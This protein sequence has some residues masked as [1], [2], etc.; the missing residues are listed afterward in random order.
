MK[1]IGALIL[2]TLFVDAAFSQNQDSI[3][4]IGKQVQ[5]S[6]T[7]NPDSVRVLADA[8]IKV[9]T[10]D[11][12][13]ED[14]GTLMFLD[15][16]YQRSEKDD[17]LEYLT[18]TVAKDKTKNRPAFISI[19]VPNNVSISNGIF[20]KFGN[21]I[22]DKD[23]NRTIKLE[24]GNP[25]RIP[26]EQSNPQKDYYSARIIDGYAINEDTKEKIDIFQKFLSSDHVYFLFI[27]PDGSHKSVGVPLFSFKK[28]YK[29]IGIA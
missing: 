17:S 23:S 16:A 22:T 29:N 25:L 1:K 9:F 7:K 2:M 4:A 20:I 18:L 13:K 14:K 24:P 12:Q 15:V 10:W 5:T 27:Y 21:T 3:N 6:Y 11:I 19:I 28:Q 8:A 26:F